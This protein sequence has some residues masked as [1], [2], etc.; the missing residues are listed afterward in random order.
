MIRAADAFVAHLTSDGTALHYS[1]YLGG[2]SFDE[3][4]GIAVDQRGRAYI[5]GTT[6]SSNFPVVDALQ[7]VFGGGVQDAFVARLS[8][9][10]STLGYSTYLGGSGR[11]RGRGIT[12]DK[13][14]QAYVTGG[15]DSANFPTENALQPTY[16][17]GIDAFIAK[18]NRPGSMLVYSTYLGGGKGGEEGFGIATDSLGQTYVTGFTSSPD[19]PTMSALQPINRGTDIFVVKIGRDNQP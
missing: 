12:V 1:T 15:T 14:G 13:R 8:V 17:G 19:F 3:G 11:D 7:Q 5:V 16:G 6:E 2:S 18:L 10:G 4:F 9:D